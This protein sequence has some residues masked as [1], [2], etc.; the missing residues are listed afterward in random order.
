MNSDSLL[1]IDA[2]GPF[3]RQHKPKRINW[4]KIPFSDLEDADGLKPK[5]L[6]TI[7]KD[8]RKFCE[9]A[10]KHG[11]NAISLD[12]VAHL[13]DC[14][15]YESG[16][17]NKIGQYRDLFA[18]L[19]EIATQL[20]LRVFITM[21]V[22]FF[23]DTLLKHVGQN[24]AKVTAWL[25]ARLAELFSDFKGIAGIVMRF[26][27]K[28]GLDVKG[29]FRSKLLLKSVRQTRTFLKS[30]L[31][32]F[33][34]QNRLLIFRTWSVGAY[35][36]GDLIWNPKTFR[37]V[38]QS[39][40]SPSLVISMK[41][42]ESDFF[43]YLPLNPNF[44]ESSHKKI[45]EF[46]ARREYEG[47]GAYP[48]FVGWDVENDLA[49]LQG[50]KNVIGASVWC[51]TGGWG[52]LRQLTFIRN[53]SFWVELNV[54]V[55]AQLWNG[56][57]CEQAIGKFIEDNHLDVPLD[58]MLEFLQLSDVVIKKLLYVPEL[59]RKQLFFRRLRLPP[60]L[61]VFWDRIIID[62]T[63]KR[64]LS[65]LV[66]DREQALA[67][68]REGLANLRQMIELAD[69]HA[70]PS[71]GLNFQLETFKILAKAREYF[72]S[73]WS[74]EIASEL[75][76]MKEQY[77]RRFKRNYSIVLNFEPAPLETRQMNG[78]LSLLLRRK[79]DYRLVDEIVTLRALAWIYPLV[80]R[81]GRKATPKFANKQAM[82]ID[83]LF[84]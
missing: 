78:L 26:G 33:E 35:S 30:I 25:K 72:F 67:D 46:Q 65:C 48:S 59:A 24:H 19:I 73:S 2:I 41:Y 50:A 49:Q 61:F 62:H 83:V 54:A 69:R 6:T 9:S 3:F 75:F 40:D 84:K 4:S 71:K 64:I 23:N 39:I 55:I 36:I 38:F 5:F 13:V 21:D 29:D 66:D 14:A 28:D 43:R 42:G 77:K 32:T 47:F 68:G 10:R 44:F 16:L 51:Q 53:S 7:E 34:K 27:E 60:Q 15:S 1:I 70:I 12:D 52:K 45:I 57:S 82:G 56:N 20:E 8:F 11:Y 22:M 37:K 31:P 81:F 76:A 18:I 63:I 80:K 17:R 74:E 58:A 79:A